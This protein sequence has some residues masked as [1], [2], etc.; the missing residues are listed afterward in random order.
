MNGTVNIDILKKA[1]AI[2]LLLI[3]T[4]IIGVIGY[5]LTEKYTVLEALWQTVITLSTVGFGELREMSQPGRIFT[6]VL[7]MFGF[8]LF[9]Y[10]LTSLTRIV[11]EGE[12][13]NIF[14]NRKM[15]KEISNMKNHVILCGHGRL[16]REIAGELKK[17]RKEYVVIEMDETV[18]QELIDQ[19]V[20]VVIGDATE[21][22]TLIKA[23]IKDAEGAIAALTDDV[24]NLFVTLTARKL[25][26]GLTIVTKAD[27]EG[28]E[29][30]LISAGANKVISPAQ[31]G[32]RR[33]ASVL[34]NPE[35]VNFL[36]VVV[37][38]KEFNLSMQE[39][40]V[41][42]NSIIEGLPIKDAQ[43]PR[44]IKVIGMKKEDGNMHINPPA[45]HEL[46]ADSVLIVLGENVHIEKLLGMAKGKV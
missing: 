40:R 35:V 19:H 44:E 21:D 25:N 37:C 43:I 29:A 33:M 18:G 8:A 41:Q 34:I 16:G 24:K 15:E 31:I 17:W 36:D 14:R 27:Q 13:K 2:L 46:N 45:T 3:M 28:S 4:I 5:E 32:G 22:E 7:I 10:S 12:I 42:K 20:P 1:F 39:V 11:V 26:P 23:G 30:K 9:G 6:I 38:E